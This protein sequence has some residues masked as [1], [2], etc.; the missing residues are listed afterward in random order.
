MLV[1]WGNVCSHR[2]EVADWACEDRGR[3][4]EVY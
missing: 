3:E 1:I 4:E 2:V